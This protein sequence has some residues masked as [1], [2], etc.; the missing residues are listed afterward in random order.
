RHDDVRHGF[1]RLYGRLRGRKRCRRVL[2]HDDQVAAANATFAQA[3]CRLANKFAVHDGHTPVVLA[4]K[5]FRYLPAVPEVTQRAPEFESLLT[6][7]PRVARGPG[8]REH[9][10]A[11][12]GLELLLKLARR[13]R[14]QQNPYT[15][16]AVGRLA[17]AEF[18]IDA[19]FA[20]A[21]DDG[22]G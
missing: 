1:D 2:T 6:V 19:C 9:A 5:A 17:W 11:N 16:A 4:G 13:N 7:E 15:R 20:T 21:A 14:E 22:R 18:A 8:A 3:G 12:P 10:L